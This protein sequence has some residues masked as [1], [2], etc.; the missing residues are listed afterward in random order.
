LVLR[1]SSASG[2]LTPRDSKKVKQ[3]NKKDHDKS[4]LS[5]TKSESIDGDEDS[6][7]IEFEIK[8]KVKSKESPIVLKPTVPPEEISIPDQ[9]SPLKRKSPDDPSNP[10]EPILISKDTTIT[11]FFQAIGVTNQPAEE[12]LKNN[13]YQTVAHLEEAPPTESDLIDRCKFTIKEKNIILSRISGPGSLPMPLPKTV[14]PL[15]ITKKK[16]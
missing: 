11:V 15:S 13:G 16:N 2:L 7:S 6:I 9:I 12:H 8:K 10:S 3:H 14:K 1:C 5:S 4:S